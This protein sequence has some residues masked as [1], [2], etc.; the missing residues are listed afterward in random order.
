MTRDELHTAFKV[1][2]DKNS[3]SVA[4]GGCPAFID[5]EIDYWINKGYYNLLM[6]KFTG[7]TANEVKFEGDVK[8]VADYERL[9]KTDK[10]ITL[11]KDNNSN[12]ASL[13][14]LLNRDEDNRG[15]MFYVS[16]VFHWVKDGI[17]HSATTK[18][19]D[20][21]QVKRFIKTDNNNPWIEDPI[22]IIENN[23]LIIYYDP[24]S[25][26]SDN[27]SLDLTYIKHPQLI[28][29]L[30]KDSA[31]S[32]LPDQAWYEVINRAVQLALENIE[33]QRIQT[34]T[35]LIKSEE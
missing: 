24:I 4:Y 9:I 17:Q 10:N 28:T 23:T 1:E 29:E 7:G 34:K 13:S 3:V 26:N 32:E 20:H 35:G 16:S 33:S 5:S 27:Y 12:S 31:L 15:R 2:M 14:N 30:P 25:M 19:L 6:Q 11:T 18:L 8:R 21:T 22:G